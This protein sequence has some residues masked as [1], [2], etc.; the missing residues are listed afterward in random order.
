MKRF[1]LYFLCCIVADN[2]LAQQAKQSRIP[3]FAKMPAENRYDSINA[4]YVHNVYLP[5]VDK[6][7]AERSLLMMEA[8]AYAD[9]SNDMAT[10]ASMAFFTGHF[11]S[12]FE[13]D[14]ARGM[15]YI[16]EAFNIAEKYSLQYE[17]AS[18]TLGL[19]LMYRD[20]NKA[21]SLESL[22]RAIEVM[23]RVSVPNKI[24]VL[25]AKHILGTL[26]FHLGNYG[27]CIQT[28]IP[29]LNGLEGRAIKIDL[30]QANNTVGLAYREIGDNDSAL[31]YFRKVL[32]S[33]EAKP[34]FPS[35]IG[36]AAGNI[37]SVYLKQ[38]QL[39]SALIYALKNYDLVKDDPNVSGV[40][41]AEALVLL[42]TVYLEQHKT[43]QVISLLSPAEK[44]I[45]A[46]QIYYSYNVEYLLLKVNYILAR[47]YHD[48]G[49][50]PPRPNRRRWTG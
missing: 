40:G 22:T 24:E 8:R 30:I 41:V 3:E 29:V 2:A 16:I 33:A 47:A 49:D 38:H 31:F 32:A 37:G 39:D 20:N 13:R 11:I 12:G 35:W 28:L 50:Q 4:W 7:I 1:L 17:W 44:L 36:I 48:K 9:H 34:V 6:S 15:H 42:S 19:G 27:A 10:K 18:Y 5:P 25:Y 26:Y 45:T 21:K 46:K 14:S 43:D 23:D